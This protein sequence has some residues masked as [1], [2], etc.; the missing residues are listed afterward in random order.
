[1][2]FESIMSE[3][4]EVKHVHEGKTRDGKGRALDETSSPCAESRNGVISYQGEA[5]GDTY[6]CCISDSALSVYINE[7]FRR[8]RWDMSCNDSPH[9]C[10]DFPEAESEDSLERIN[11]KLGYLSCVVT[12]YMIFKIACWVFG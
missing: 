7:M 10:G 1:M 2:D 3:S 12:I 8:D 11:D 5:D 6:N 9:E 4:Y